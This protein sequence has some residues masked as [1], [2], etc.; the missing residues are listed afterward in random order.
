ML[1][2][3]RSEAPLQR[4]ELATGRLQGGKRNKAERGELRFPLPVGLC[5]DEA[6]GIVLDPD[7][8]VQGVLRTVFRSFSLQDQPGFPG[9]PDNAD[10][11]DERE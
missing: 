4:Q 2:A 9:A 3:S 5:W 8:E 10:S 6:G 1:H 11:T 7:Q